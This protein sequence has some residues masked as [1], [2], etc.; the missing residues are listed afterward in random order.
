MQIIDNF[1]KQDQFDALKNVITSPTI[2]WFQNQY[3]VKPD[4]S[5]QVD[6]IY[7]WQ[8]THTFYKNYSVSSEYFPVLDSIL[9]NLNPSAILRI[10]ANLIPRTDKSVVYQYHTDVSN[11]KGKTAVFYI[12]SNNGYTLFKDGSRVESIENR[13]VIFDST[14]EHTGTSCTDSRNRCVINF[15][16]YTWDKT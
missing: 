3:L 16:Y 11:F 12:N 13:I 10:K 4:N 14:L 8:F 5:H 9:V 1:L 6:D 15:N 2:P 7:N